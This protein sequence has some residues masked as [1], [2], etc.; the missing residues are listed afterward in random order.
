MNEATIVL[1]SQIDQSVN[2]VDARG[3]E[4][5]YVERDEGKTAIIYLSSHAGCDRACRMCWLTQTGQTDMTPATMD[6]YLTQARA[7]L[8]AM[9]ERRAASGLG[10]P[11]VVHFNFMA[12]G[13][14]MKNPVIREKFDELAS[15]LESGVAALVDGFTG[16]VKFKI[17][18][19]MTDIY[20]KD[21]DGT[22]LDGMSQ[23]PFN[24]YKPEIYYSLY[25]MNP[26]FRKRWLPKAEEPLDALRLLAAYR[27]KGGE[28]RIHSAFIAGHNDDMTDVAKMVHTVKMY[29]FKKFNIVRFNSIDTDKWVETDEEY[30]E[31]IK[32]FMESKGLEVQMVSRVGTDVAASCG[33]FVSPEQAP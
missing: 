31:G 21:K 1:K 18:T 27:G 14:P 20:V 10:V 16:Q 17:S 5:R 23:L 4:T 30:L 28:V 22:Y 11:E 6:D 2:T 26:E 12:R 15:A 24:R 9:Q 33:T 13:E 19:I 8:E 25:S 32:T 3:F 29:G 7:S